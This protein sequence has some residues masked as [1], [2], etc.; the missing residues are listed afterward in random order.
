MTGI[1]NW[2][3][4]T[5]WLVYVKLVCKQIKADICNWYVNP[6]QQVYVTDK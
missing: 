5:S 6:S 4:N 3:V 2:Y 1:S